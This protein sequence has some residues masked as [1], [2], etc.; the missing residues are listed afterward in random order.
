MTDIP[1][2]SAIADVLKLW[3]R[4][5]WLT[6]PLTAVVPC[7]APVRGTATTITIVAGES[8]PGLGPVYR[9]L[10]SS[11][12]DRFVVVGGAGAVDGAVWGEIMSAA[13]DAQGAAGALV[14]GWVRDA[15]E[16]ERIGLP[17]YA[18]DQCVVGP[19]GTAHAVAV[20]DDVVVG[21][22]LIAAGDTI[23]ADETGCVRIPQ[24]EVD[25]VLGAARAYAAGEARVVQA[26]QAGEPLTRAYVH[27]KTAVDEL[28]R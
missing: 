6:P 21:G 22:V 11:L 3:G 16:M 26:L 18:A 5:G 9:L 1:S 7:S 4:D 8:G 28:R 17:V 27:K 15:P 2:V 24:A 23:V 14:D 20:D 10:S 13:A 25:E 19:N 12:F